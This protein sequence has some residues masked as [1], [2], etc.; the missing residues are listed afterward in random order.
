M[1]ILKHILVVGALLVTMLP[2]SHAVAHHEHEHGSAMEL[3]EVSASPCECHSCDHEPC[4]DQC[5]IEFNPAPG[6]LVIEQPPSPTVLFILPEPR[7]A[8][9]EIPPPISG[10]L[11]AIQTV[12][13]L[14]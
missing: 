14:I 2:C 6:S 12:Q 11:A 13:L 3:C 4:S 7:P 8:K 1:N 5:E 10:F 9:N